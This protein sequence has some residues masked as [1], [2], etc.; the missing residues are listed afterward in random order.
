MDKLVRY[1]YSNAHRA[2]QHF[3]ELYLLFW[4][5]YLNLVSEKNYS[6][7]RARLKLLFLFL[8]CEAGRVLHFVYVY[9]LLSYL[10]KSLP[11]R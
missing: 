1:V 10:L 3:K 5:K 7:R 6:G 4:G 11:I 9:L 8:V 2:A